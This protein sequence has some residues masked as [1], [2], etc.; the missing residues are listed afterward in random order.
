MLMYFLAREHRLTADEKH[1]NSFGT[2]TK[3]T[4]TPGQPT[5]YPS[6]LPGFFPTLYQCFCKMEPFD[7]P[8]LNGLHL[9]EGLCEGVHLG[10]EA[11][12]GFPSLQTLPHTASLGHHGVNVH[13]SESRNKSMIVHIDN[14]HEH[15]KVADIAQEMIGKR[16]FHNWPFLQ[17]GTVSAISDSLF[18]YEKLSMFPGKP[19]KV[20]SN[21]HTPQG[22]GLWK[23]KAEKIERYYS[24][25]CGVITGNIEVI[26][27][28]RPLKG[29]H[30]TSIVSGYPLY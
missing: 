8:T 5:E 9:I 15:R 14:A 28:V 20:V 2:S 26:L 3:F 19:A 10:A 11:L 4:Y 23:S 24:K 6:S 12:A 29:R 27:H 13:G 17:E 7:L 22:L 25:R 16:V 18:M 30:K 1:R 21:P